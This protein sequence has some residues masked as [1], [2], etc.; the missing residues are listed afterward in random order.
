MKRKLSHLEDVDLTERV[1]QLRTQ[2]VERHAA[3]QATAMAIQP[4]LTDLSR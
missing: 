4:S 3:L 2:R 1:M